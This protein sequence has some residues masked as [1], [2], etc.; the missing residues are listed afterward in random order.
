[1]YV[2]VGDL[3]AY[4]CIAFTLACSLI[5]WRRASAAPSR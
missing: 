1:V 2:L 3:F 5:A 4:L